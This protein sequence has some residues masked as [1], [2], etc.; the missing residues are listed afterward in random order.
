MTFTYDYKL[1]KEQIPYINEVHILT[2]V[3][4]TNRYVKTRATH[5]LILSYTQT[6]GRGRV[7]KSF[8]S[9]ANKGIYM[10]INLGKLPKLNTPLTI[11]GVLAVITALEDI[12]QT[13]I[14]I[15]WL[16]DIYINNKKL[17]GV[18]VESTYITQ[19][20]QETIIG[21]GINIYSSIIL[22]K[23][24]PQITTH[25]EE[26]TGKEIDIN[27]IVIDITNRLYDYLQH[28][29]KSYIQE[30]RERLCCLHT[31][32]Q[33]QNNEMLYVEDIDDF[34]RLITINAD[35]KKVIINAGEIQLKKFID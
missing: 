19:E 7:G 20:V 16:N 31:E 4:S 32:V 33:T 17:G 12:T 14:D 30:Y 5:D 11:I 35:G 26:W 25:L 21:I 18:L 1:L 34:G 27:A 29:N 8:I 22:Q 6:K 3:D 23:E 28:P 9:P 15:M 24:I 13:P 2:S 10:S